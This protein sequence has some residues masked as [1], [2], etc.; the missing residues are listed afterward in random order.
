M[1]YEMG[2][3]STGDVQTQAQLMQAAFEQHS[4][5]IS[6]YAVPTEV[7]N[8]AA[9]DLEMAIRANPVGYATVM[10]RARDRH[11]SSMETEIQS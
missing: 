11:N 6:G 5:V 4:L 7:M 9:Y 10:Q 2:D 3:A 1:S 8:Q